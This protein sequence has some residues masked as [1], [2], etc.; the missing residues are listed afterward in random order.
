MVINL[1]PLGGKS[2]RV[3]NKTVLVLVLSLVLLLG[4]SLSFA[5]EKMTMEEYEAQL[6]EWQTKLDAADKGKTEC[7]TANEALQQEMDAVKA[8]TD[9]VWNEILAEIGTDQSGVDA[10]RGDLNALNAQC[11]GL[12]ALTPEELFQ[13]RDEVEALCGKLGEAKSNRISAL[14]EMQNLIATIEGKLTQIKNKMPKAV[15]DEYSV[16]VGDYLWKISGKADIY[17]DPTHWMRIYS[18]NAD[19]ISDPDLIYPEWILK[20]Q[21]GVGPDEYLIAKGDYLQKIAENPEVLGDAASWTKIYE[22]NKGIIGD[23]P[24]MVF[25]HTVLVIPKE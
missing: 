23:D 22:K 20:I 2:M 19:Q 15:Y 11:D 16:V 18:Y 8:E 6:A 1:K 3:T 21:R 10:F 14:T 5:Q 24:N 12:L 13:K 9:K 17:D 7:S 4:A 25:P